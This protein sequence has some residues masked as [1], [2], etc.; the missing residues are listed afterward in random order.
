MIARS[1][2]VWLLIIFVEFLHGIAR[3]VFLEPYVGNLRA[4]QIGVVIGSLL[5]LAIAVAFVQWIG[6]TSQKQLLAV[7]L[8]WVGLTLAF[9]IA[10]GRFVMRLSWE[11]LLSDYNPFQGGFLAIGMI[12]LALSPLLAARLRRMSVT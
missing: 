6:A 7:G 1:L 12:I 5:I 9:E 3:A 2:I 10:F 11:R 8:L 4:R